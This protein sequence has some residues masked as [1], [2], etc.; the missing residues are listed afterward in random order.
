M[1]LS[2]RFER[3][4]NKPTNGSLHFFPNF[5]ILGR[6]SHIKEQVRSPFDFS[7]QKTMVLSS[8]DPSA[9]NHSNVS[10]ESALRLRPLLK[11]ESKDTV[12]LAQAPSIIRKA[13]ATVI[14]NPLHGVSS[15]SPIAGAPGLRG[16]T[17]SD[18]TANNIPTEYHFN[19]VLTESTSQEKV[20]YALGLPITT[21]VMN[22]MSSKPRR[23]NTGTKS[24]VLVCMGVAGSGKTYTCLGGS[25][26]PTD[27]ALQGLVPKLV[28]SLF[29]HSK[30]N[31]SGTGAKGF[32]VLVSMAQV[33]HTKGADPQECTIHD[34][35]ATGTGT[36]TSEKPKD[37]KK[38]TPKRNLTVR[39]MAAKFERVIGSP[40]RSSPRPSSSEIAELDVDNIHLSI[41]ECTD[42]TQAR[43]VLQKGLV[44]SAKVANGQ[45]HHL[46]IT[47]QPVTDGTHLGD[48]I[49]ILDMAGLEK[50]RKSLSRG[51][52][53]VA[54]KNQ[55]ASAA[56]LHCLR[57][58]I[59]NTNVR[60]GKADPIDIADDTISD[61]SFVS[62]EKD[63]LRRQMKPVPF[64]QHK[65]T[66]LL[67]PL[68][69]QSVSSKV[70]LLLAAYP[71]H[72]DYSEKRILL[73]DME[74]LCGAAL[75][76]TR[77]TAAT[78]L[79][80]SD[81]RSFGRPPTLD[82]E[83]YSEQGSVR[84]FKIHENN[85]RSSASS[86][87]LAL[88][89]SLDEV[90]EN[91]P[92]PPPYAPS[93]SKTLQATNKVVPVPTAPP[94]DSN[95]PV[96][97]HANPGRIHQS[98]SKP[99]RNPDYVSD[100]P[101]V[102]LPAKKELSNPIVERQRV[103][104]TLI[105]ANV[106]GRS[107]PPPPNDIMRR[108]P[109]LEH[110]A[111]M[112][113]QVIPESKNGRQPLG[114]SSLENGTPQEESDKTMDSNKY[115]TRKYHQSKDG[116]SPKALAAISAP[117]QGNTSSELTRPSR[118]VAGEK[119]TTHNVKNDRSIREA[120]PVRSRDH[121]EHR[122]DI[123]KPSTDDAEQKIRELER[124]MRELERAKAIYERKCSDLEGENEKLKKTVKQ[125]VAQTQSQWTA[126]D[127]ELFQKCREARIE[128]QTL[129]KRTFRNHLERVNYIYDIKNQWCKTDKPHFDLTLPSH[130]QRAT[131][132]DI[133]DK[134]WEAREAG[135][136]LGQVRNV[137]LG[138]EVDYKPSPPP[139]V[140][141]YRPKRSKKS[142]TPSPLRALK[143]LT[144]NF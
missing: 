13:P 49:A 6:S 98:K 109:V 84:S 93:F 122:D 103:T 20:F 75:V 108:Q 90:D 96:S 119:Q 137:A 10:V 42:V 101:G 8:I 73:Q 23:P 14:L 17:E 41:E 1:S 88:S 114:R 140:K 116:G 32:A 56:V 70:T 3:R 89:A 51:K 85:Y 50:G 115:G 112:T 79:D 67:Q 24:H 117:R 142:T 63:P 22:S 69:T 102:H 104:S 76:A 53:S 91:G 7:L 21:A 126:Q 59:H 118:Q 37:K 135:I 64:R 62:Q 55:E 106:G 47:L 25:S 19:H 61:I 82:E 136:S 66:M 92:Q 113:K 5:Q 132:L 46:L 125:A 121:S 74:L 95:E 72:A 4:L 16:R 87:S 123:P 131:E 28:D 127:E 2:C 134:E 144:M 107:A 18:S 33:T 100:F 86:Q 65:V 31:A 83:D 60:N 45:N 99:L 71:G 120:D 27:R 129:V 54:N 94:L 34:L 29:S 143:K 36:G 44:N 124:K 133:R 52:D 11:K 138:A 110:D 97:L 128:D 38:M 15:A 12:L 43:E 77:G 78:G 130:F 40:I 26:I 9:F 48:K 57:T 81:S 30:H 68:F 139:P 35:L 39:N 80:R 141:T 105:S 58:M 111:F